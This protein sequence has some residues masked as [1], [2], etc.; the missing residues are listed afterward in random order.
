MI[1]L[2]GLPGSG[3]DSVAHLLEWVGFRIYTFSSVIRDEARRRGITEPDRPTLQY[4]G[5]EMRSLHGASVL[6][7]RLTVAIASDGAEL[8]VVNGVRNPAEWQ[9][10]R[11][12]ESTRSTLIAVRC[13]PEVRYRR[14][15][16]R[17]RPGDPTSPEEFDEI[18]KRDRGR[19]QEGAELQVDGV[20]DMADRNLENDHS[21]WD[22][23][24][25]LASI[26]EGVGLQESA[27]RIRGQVSAGIPGWR[28]LLF[29]LRA[30]WWRLRGR[31]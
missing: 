28:R 9:V 13:P 10:F 27:G 18:D 30:S 1:G 16:A 15:R 5:T 3:K 29:Q 4:I 11:D 2:T 22:L 7:E 24:L 26:L 6:A 19:G 21:S 31:R 17:G 8:A 14:L 20:M 23:A 12:D 25:A